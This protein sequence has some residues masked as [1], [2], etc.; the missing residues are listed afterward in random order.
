[1]V[2]WQKSMIQFAIFPAKLCERSSEKETA[3]RAAAICDTLG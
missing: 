2:I 1:M 3:V